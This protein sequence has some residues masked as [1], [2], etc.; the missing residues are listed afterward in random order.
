[1]TTTPMPPTPFLP[2]A[3]TAAEPGARRRTAAP[4]TTA[5]T[6]FSAAQW[7][8][9]RWAVRGTLV[10]GV[11]ASVIAN[12]LHARQN[13]ISQAIAAWPPLALL[14]TVELIARVPVHRRGL[15]AARL[16]ATTIIAGIA[17][18]V[19]YWHMTGVAARYGETG[20]SPYLLPLSVDGL[21]IVASISL[22][23][24]S[25]RLLTSRATHLDTA[26]ASAP[27]PAPPPAAPSGVAAPRV[28][29]AVSTPPIT[30][31]PPEL[32]SSAP[33]ATRV[34]EDVAP[35]AAQ[36]R[37]LAADRSVP[38]SESDGPALLGPA[39]PDAVVTAPDSTTDPSLDRP[40]QAPP[41]TSVPT[42][43]AQV[44][45]DVTHSGD[46]TDANVPTDPREAIAFWRHHDPTID[47]DRLAEKI[48]KSPRQVRR[49]L[50]NTRRTPA[51]QGTPVNG[52]LSDALANGRRGD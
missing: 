21:I 18:W 16:L 22:V 26:V 17:A 31:A 38:T 25:G 28:A 42:S 9:L 29:N 35:P 36:R 8:R 30:A 24:I 27:A 10:L 11:A 2:P 19:S 48:G 3:T 39:S 12:V 34:E 49:Y 4:D 52:S 13:P 37:P 7:R 5:G 45:D 23:E 32:P 1:M 44:P 41:P 51:P 46:D 47:V 33:A 15:A 20:A 6:A 50:T 43:P 14:L 40:H